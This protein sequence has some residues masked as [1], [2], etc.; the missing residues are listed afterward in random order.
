MASGPPGEY[1]EPE[2]EPDPLDPLCE[3]DPMLGQ[4]CLVVDSD[5]EVLDASVVD[6]YGAGVVV[7]ELVAADA[8]EM[9]AIAPPVASAAATIVAPSILDIR[10]VLSLSVDGRDDA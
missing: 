7:V 3:L 4:G 1:A 10:I 8:P 6:V 9:P 5:L 2:L